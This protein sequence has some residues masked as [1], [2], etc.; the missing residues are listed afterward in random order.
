MSKIMF[1]REVVLHELYQYKDGSRERGLCLDR[2]AENL[3]DVETLWFRVDQRSLRDKLKKLLQIFI[4]R[5]NHEQK[6]SGISPEHTEWDDLLQEIY[7]RKIE[8]DLHGAN[9]ESGDKAK[10]EE[11][12]AACENMRRTSM[13]CLSETKKRQAEETS[14]EEI[15]PKRNRSSI[16]Y[17]REKSEKDFKL[18]E[19]ELRLRREELEVTK[20][21]EKALIDQSNAMMQLLSKLSDK[22]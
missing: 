16:S 12:K 3:N 2:I 14:E 8:S 13:E 1:L 4:T 7:E 6:Q 15:T 18:R 9:S 22:L 17:F 21:R 5:K 10:K 19:E 20:A 11:E